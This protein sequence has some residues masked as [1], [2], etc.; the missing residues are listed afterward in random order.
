MS[1]ARCGRAFQLTKVRGKKAEFIDVSM[2]MGRDVVFAMHV[3]S[4]PRRPWNVFLCLA[5]SSICAS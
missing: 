2:G 1:I 5:K 3:S 4:F